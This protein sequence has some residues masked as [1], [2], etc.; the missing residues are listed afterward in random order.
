VAA[1]AEDAA[2]YTHDRP[3][4][5]MHCIDRWIDLHACVSI[6]TDNQRIHT[7]N[8]RVSLQSIQSLHHRSRTS[9]LQ[10]SCRQ[11]MQ[12]PT[13]RP[14]DLSTDG[15]MN[16]LPLVSQSAA[17]RP[18]ADPLTHSHKYTSVSTTS[19][20]R[21]HGHTQTYFTKDARCSL[22]D[23]HDPQAA[24]QSIHLTAPTHMVAEQ[25]L[26]AMVCHEMKRASPKKA[27]APDGLAPRSSTRPWPDRKPRGVSRNS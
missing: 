7:T 20:V 21:T 18:V 10:T 5:C 3:S 22:T 8:R 9:L 27:T 13:R 23:Y 26:R 14:T 4:E 6:L 17:S 19:A 16:Y 25:G 24:H 2:L 12:H 15:S 1:A 11:D